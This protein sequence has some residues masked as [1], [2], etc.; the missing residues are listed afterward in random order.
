MKGL[1]ILKNIDS[2]LDAVPEE[3]WAARGTSRRLKQEIIRFACATAGASLAHRTA[4]KNSYGYIIVIIESHRRRHGGH[5]GVVMKLAWTRGDPP[6]DEP[7]IALSGDAQVHVRDS[8][9]LSHTD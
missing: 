6:Y 7:S 2:G 8:T 3:A 5:G 1:F 4:S 9:G